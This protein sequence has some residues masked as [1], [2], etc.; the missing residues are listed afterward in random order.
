MLRIF[1]GHDTHEKLAYEVADSSI[2]ASYHGLQPL[3]IKP[4]SFR[5]LR[6]EYCRRTIV[7]RNGNLWDVISEAPMSTQHAIARFFIP[8]L[9]NGMGWALFMDSDIL[10]RRSIDELFQ[11][12][13]PQYAVM[14][15]KHEYAPEEGLKKGNQHFQL[16]YARKNWS[17]VMLWNLGHPAHEKLT[18]EVLN[19]VPGRDLHRF[20]WLKD[21]EIGELSDT[22]NWLVGHSTSPDPAIVHYTEGIPGVG[23]EGMPYAAEWWGHT[24]NFVR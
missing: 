6:R 1:L 18:L 13:D 9:C 14:V 15:V 2:R 16:P 24:V 5:L 21:E 8:H 3:S 19:S 22:W 11:L 7:D 23:N 20:F 10:C 17:S 4:I 12:A